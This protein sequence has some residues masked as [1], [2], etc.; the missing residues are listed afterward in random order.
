MP[1]GKGL[2]RV[3]LRGYCCRSPGEKE[4]LKGDGIQRQES[5][6]SSNEENTIPSADDLL[7]AFEALGAGVVFIDRGCAVIYADATARTFLNADAG[8]LIGRL[9]Y[10]LV[11]DGFGRLLRERVEPALHGRT[12]TGFEAWCP[13]PVGRWL[14]CRC[15]PSSGGAMAVLEDITCQDKGRGAGMSP[16]RPACQGGRVPGDRYKALFD[17]MPQAVLEY[18][19]QGRLVAANRAA[20]EISG[21]DMEA[22]RG[23][24]AEE[25]F[26][27]V[28][29]VC[30]EDGTALDADSLPTITSLATGREVMNVVMQIVFPGKQAYQWIRHD[31][32][33]WFE[34][35]DGGPGGVFAIFSDITEIKNIQDALS[36]VNE[37]LER[38]VQ[39]QTEELRRTIGEIEKQKETLKTIFDSIPAMLVFHDPSRQSSMANRA[40][41]RLTGWSLAGDGLAGLLVALFPDPG[42]REEVWDFITA[43]SGIWK[44]FEITTRSGESLTSSWLSVRLSDGSLIGIGVDQRLCMQM[45]N[46]LA[47]F[48]SAVE[49]AEDGIVLISVDRV[50]EYINPAFEAIT[51]Y[52]RP[53]VVG[54]SLGSFVEYFA[55]ER[56]GEI[57]DS[58]ASRQ[59]AWSGRQ[60]RKRKNGEIFDAS[61]SITPICDHTGRVVN[62]VS[63]MRDITRETVAQHRLQ[64]ARQMEALGSLA[65]GIAHDL[66]N[67][68]SPILLDTET[69]MQDMGIQHP[70]YPVLDEIHKATTLGIDMVKQIHTFSHSAPREKAPLDLYPLV[71]RFLSFLRSIMSP[72]IDIDHRLCPEGA[73]VMADATQIQQV[74]MNLG[75]NARHAMR[76]KGGLLTVGLAKVDLDEKAA[77]GISP[78]LAPGPYVEMVVEDTGEGMDT[79]IVDR[80]FEPF[81]TTKKQGEGSGMGLAVV[82]GIVSDHKGVIT[83]RTSPGEGSAFRVLLPRL[84]QNALAAKPGRG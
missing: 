33:P 81:F 1:G 18:D 5:F 70:F 45:G 40:F 75:I 63:I 29:K 39:E 73:V 41:E 22:M 51:G 59:Q 84:P 15:L 42:C 61:I 35:T 8:S 55:D 27:S 9:L 2:H 65:G 53:E 72:M 14:R 64:H 4:L 28:P 62:Y 20:S 32:I 7:R 67:I 56:P 19:A 77:A 57:F 44:E 38:I 83:V 71:R 79:G 34:S 16:A 26:A 82:H 17:A 78:G 58:I 66:K 60:K 50:V 31:A 43:A 23:C 36:M 21:V 3:Q 25:V 69:L 74:L 49:Q 52:T 37:N 11:P 46:D 47:K 10:D 13:A 80:I 6:H 76:R 30:R 54:L 12:E 68:F 48:A 24:T